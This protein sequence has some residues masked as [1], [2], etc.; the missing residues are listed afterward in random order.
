MFIQFID[1]L[2]DELIL[3][4]HLEEFGE[5][6]L[7]SGRMKEFQPMLV[8]GILILERIDLDNISRLGHI[9]DGVDISINDSILE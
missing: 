9:A 7:G 8:G 1:S 4:L 2:S 3:L 5:I 6:I